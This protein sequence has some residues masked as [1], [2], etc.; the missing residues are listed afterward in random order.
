MAILQYLLWFTVA[1][2]SIGLTVVN[3]FISQ[4]SVPDDW[5]VWVGLL[6]YTAHWTLSRIYSVVI[7][8][9]ETIVD[10]PWQKVLFWHALVAVTLNLLAQNYLSQ[11]KSM[12]SKETLPTDDNTVKNE[13]MGL[14]SWRLSL[15]CSCWFLHGYWLYGFVQVFIES[16]NGSHIALMECLLKC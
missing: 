1:A 15:L 16:E 9:T 8:T 10:L 5:R 4:E 2:S 12:E 14:T 3:Y 13:R 11:E 7:T 6:G